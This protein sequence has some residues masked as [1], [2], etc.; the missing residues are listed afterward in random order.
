MAESFS[1]GAANF[2]TAP[3]DLSETLQSLYEQYHQWCG[4]K[5]YGGDVEPLAQGLLEKMYDSAREIGDFQVALLDAEAGALLVS[6][7]KGFN[8]KISHHKESGGRGASVTS[9]GVHDG[10]NRGDRMN[11]DIDALTEQQS[12][13]VQDKLNKRGMYLDSRTI[14]YFMTLRTV[15]HESAHVI[16]G[17][18]GRLANKRDGEAVD[19]MSQFF[20]EAAQADAEVINEGFAEGYA[21]IVLNKVLDTLGYDEGSKQIMLDAMSHRGNLQMQQLGYDP[22]PPQGV[23]YMLSYASEQIKQSNL[24]EW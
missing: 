16:Q 18:V 22:I 20:T 3:A 14:G 4:A 9:R 24:D 5:D 2:Y 15:A 12:Q 17:S 1:Q 11:V 10:L 6:A 8:L 13:I 19:Y 7:G 21:E 23:A